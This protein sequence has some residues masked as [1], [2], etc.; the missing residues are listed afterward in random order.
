M[1]CPEQDL[2][3]HIRRILQP[4]YSASANS[5]IRAMFEFN[6]AERERF[7]LSVRLLLQ[8]FSRLAHSTTLAPL[9]EVSFLR[10][11]SNIRQHTIL[12]NIFFALS[13]KCLICYILAWRCSR[14]A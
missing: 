8:Q 4:E 11:I 3:L 10:Q 7:E 6:F 2:N 14:S 1:L 9:R 13:C 12:H 5:A